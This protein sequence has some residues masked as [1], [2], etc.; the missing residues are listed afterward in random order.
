MGAVKPGQ[1]IQGKGTGTVQ[2]STP[3]L[4]QPGQVSTLPP[5]GGGLGMGGVAGKGNAPVQPTVPAQGGKGGGQGGNPEQLVALQAALQGQL[6]ATRP[7]PQQPIPAQ[8]GKFPANPQQ[9]TSVPGYAQPYVNAL[10]QGQ[11]T[12]LAPNPTRFVTPLRPTIRSAN[13]LR[14]AYAP[15]PATPRPSGP[16]PSLA[17][18]LGGLGSLGLFR[19]NM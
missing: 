5:Q 2:P 11:N 1:T 17:S 13:Q 12:P 6:D 3:T 18:Q 4:A 7:T 14:A 8:G 19:G 16:Q 9:P 15:Q 10:I